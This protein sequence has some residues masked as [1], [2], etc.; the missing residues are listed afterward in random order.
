MLVNLYGYVIAVLMLPEC[1]LCDQ[2]RT[3]LFWLQEI[4]EECRSE[5][6]MTNQQLETK[7]DVVLAMMRE[8]STDEVGLLKNSYWECCVLVLQVLSHRM[9][10]ANS[11]LEQILQGYIS[12][13]A[14]MKEKSSQ[15]PENVKEEL[16][17]YDTALCQYF[18]VSR[19]PPVQKVCHHAQ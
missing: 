4:L 19:D 2:I 11:L 6:N 14:T 16:L 17:R 18:G 8:G 10:E 12:F 3:I 1:S 7:L 9:D 13:H 15:H 5:H